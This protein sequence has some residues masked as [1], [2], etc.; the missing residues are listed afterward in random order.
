[1]QQPSITREVPLLWALLIGNFV[2][3]TGVLLPAGLLNE[4]SASLG[5]SI[6]T[7]GLLMLAGGLVVGIGAPVLA[8]LTNRIDRR[9]LLAGS[10]LLYAVGHAAAAIAPN[11][12]VLLVVRTIAMAAA[13]L[14]TPQAA[15]TLGLVVPAERRASAISFI[16]MGWS[17]ASVIGIPA[18]TVLA[19]AGGWRGA[20][21][22]MALISGIG[23]ASVWVT[24]P[25]GLRAPQL[26]LSSWLQVAKSPVL[27]VILLVTLASMAGQFTIVSYMAPLLTQGYGA[28]ATQV[29]MMFGIYGVFGVIGNYMASRLVGRLGLERSI[30]MAICA[31]IVG[32]FIFLVSFG[33]YTMAAIGGI[34]WGLGSFSSNSMQ[35]SRLVAVMPQLAAVT[36]ALNTSAVYLG[37]SAGAAMGGV[38]IRHGVSSLIVAVGLACLVAAAA[39]SLAA[40]WLKAREGAVD[41]V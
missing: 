14:F 27:L 16:F 2:I 32:V 4:L 39:L 33:N 1:M 25:R 8:G 23:A 11:F 34:V 5:S 20:F 26:H 31:L 21:A 13:A 10:L 28:T 19:Q 15:A 38:V 17:M 6:A 37:Q 22:L 7:T 29:A 18:G 9:H 41:R 12:W 36:V 3:G 30:F 24:V 35:Q 40:S